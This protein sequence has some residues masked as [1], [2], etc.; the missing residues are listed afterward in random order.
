MRV[1]T[2]RQADDGLGLD[3]QREAI[4]AWARDNGHRLIDIVEDAGVS[5]TLAERE[6]LATLL[7]R[8]ERGEALGVVVYRLD[9]LA[10]DL[11]VQEQLLAELWRAGTTVFSTAG[12]EAAYLVD[13]PEDPSRR[14]IRHMLGAVADYE[15]AMIRLRLAAG[16]RR[17]GDR[18]GFAYGAPPFGSR[19]VQGE[20]TGHP[21]EEAVQARIVQLHADGAS[22]RGIAA[23][24]TAE[25]HLPRHGGRWHPEVLRRIVQ[26]GPRS[27]VRP[28]G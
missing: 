5:G 2:D 22:L 20:L 9:R 10:R 4:R 25:G 13:D 11:V 28:G 18:G 15:R 19:A 24:L 12:G 6:G 17:K 8:L 7:P 3:V 1:S 21:V 23:T 27:S 14:L 26:R 16:R